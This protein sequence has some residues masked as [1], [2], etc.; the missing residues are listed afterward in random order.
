MDI[1]RVASDAE[2]CSSAKRDRRTLL[3]LQYESEENTNSAGIR[4]LDDLDLICNEE[5]VQL[6]K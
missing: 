6:R 1:K 2:V 4:R 5:E 3:T